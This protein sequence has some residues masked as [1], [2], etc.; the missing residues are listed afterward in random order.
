[1]DKCKQYGDGSSANL[2]HLAEGFALLLL[3]RHA[4]GHPLLVAAQLV[5]SLNL[6]ELHLFLAPV[7]LPLQPHE[8]QPENILK[9]L[10]LQV[11]ELC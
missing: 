6:Q 8:L 9:R 1:M 10:P 3:F 4:L 7:P 5:I 11:Y 2:P